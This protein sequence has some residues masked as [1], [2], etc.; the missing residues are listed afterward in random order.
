MSGMHNETTYTNIENV[1]RNQRKFFSRLM[2]IC[3]ST[4]LLR[5]TVVARSF[6]Q[7]ILFSIFRDEIATAGIWSHVLEVSSQLVSKLSHNYVQVIL[8]QIASDVGPSRKEYDNSICKVRCLNLH[9][10]ST[11]EVFLVS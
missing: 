1:D 10:L 4:R 7:Q 9:G 11:Y 6:D 2:F 8:E 3:S 5:L